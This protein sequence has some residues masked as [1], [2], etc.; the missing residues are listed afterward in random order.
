VLDHPILRRA[1]L[2]EKEYVRRESP[3][4]LV[5]KEGGLV[6]GM[7]DLAFPDH[8]PEFVGWTV[9]DFKTDREFADTSNHYIAQ[10]RVYSQAVV[11]ATRAPV[12]GVLL[13]V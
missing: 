10:V 1:A 13:V 6:E 8:T 3:V 4:M 11:K 9:V 7:I 2:V 12:R 5:L